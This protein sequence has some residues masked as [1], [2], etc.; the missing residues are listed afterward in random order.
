MAAALIRRERFRWDLLPGERE[1]GFEASSFRLRCAVPC[2]EGT[3]LIGCEASSWQR[4]AVQVLLELLLR[5]FLRCLRHVRGSL[6]RNPFLWL[7]ASRRFV[8]DPFFEPLGVRKR[9]RALV[10]G[11]IVATLGRGM[12]WR[13]GASAPRRN[14]LPRLV[15]GVLLFCQ[16]PT[17][18]RFSQRSH[19]AITI[20]EI[21]ARSRGS[22]TNSGTV[23]AAAVPSSRTSGTVRRA[24]SRSNWN[25]PYDQCSV[26]GTGLTA[27]VTIPLYP[28]RASS[29][30]TSLNSLPK[31]LSVFRANVRESRQ[32]WER[33]MDFLEAVGH[34]PADACPWRGTARR[35]RGG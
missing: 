23:N 22:L 3:N 19:A 18:W 8:A 28:P 21:S 17:P 32:G 29:N 13:L 2:E 6:S 35:S 1:A 34:E 4:P 31:T 24:V 9:G 30:P 26:S 25:D 5:V 33:S 11:R 20:R 27:S 12:C 10:R 14:C 7:I 16:A 15:C